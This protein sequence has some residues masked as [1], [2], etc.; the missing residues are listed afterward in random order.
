MIRGAISG[1]YPFPFIHAGSLGS[2]RVL[3]NAMML[4][5]GFLA[6]GLLLVAVDKLQRP[7][8]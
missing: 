8:A 2:A 5:A 4:F 1:R 7:K 3:S 6:A